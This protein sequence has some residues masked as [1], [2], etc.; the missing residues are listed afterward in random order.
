MWASNNADRTAVKTAADKVEKE[1]NKI[2]TPETTTERAAKAAIK[3]YLEGAGIVNTASTEVEV[4]VEV[5]SFTASSAAARGSATVNIT[6][7]KGNAVETVEGLTF[8]LETVMGESGDTVEGITSGTGTNSAGVNAKPDGSYI[9]TDAG[10]IHSGDI[11]GEAEEN[12][13]FK[14][15]VI[16]A[17]AYSGT[18]KIYDEY[19]TVMYSETATSTAAATSE[20]H[21]FYVQVISAAGD[22]L[23]N[24]GSGPMKTKGLPAGNYTWEITGTNVADVSGSFTIG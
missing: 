17:G 4:E 9:F 24:A 7:K 21:H 13:F 23:V 10:T 14:F 22:P 1:D 8:R 19:G 5:T 16:A 6:L 3:A 20:G 2:V 11:H 15:T 18:L 12:I